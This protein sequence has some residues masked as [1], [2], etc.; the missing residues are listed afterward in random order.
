[1][2]EF[3]RHIKKS[4]HK[5]AIAVAI[6]LASYTASADIVTSVK[7]LGFIASSIAEGV[8]ETQVLVPP[9]ASPHDTY[10]KP[11]DVLLLKKAD[12]AIWIGEDV[13]ANFSKIINE[14]L[15]ADKKLQL[16][17]LEEIED[18]L[19]EG[20]EGHDHSHSHNHHSDSH[21]E[22]DAEH[23]HNHA[24]KQEGHSHAHDHHHDSSVNWHI[25]YSPQ[26]SH[27]VA[28][29]IAE[30][31]T[32]IYPD[33]KQRIAKNLAQFEQ[34]LATQSEKIKVQ[35]AP[36]KDRGF[37]VFHDAYGYFNTAY[38]LN[39]TGYFTINPLVAP[40]AKTL[41]KIK[42]EIQQHKVSCL[43]AEPQFT[44]KVIE[45]L[46]QSTGVKVGRL[47]PIGDNVQLGK[48]SYAAFLQ[49]TADSYAQ[50]LAQ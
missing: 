32:H 13:D 18:L 21:E 11:S 27:I 22:E 33:K 10:L 1:M 4:V 24:H 38:G 49:A 3:T 6:S 2:S 19:I 26:I 41:A 44:P 35:L 7:P 36:Y 23:S 12:L 5:S 45:S 46:S 16:S 50:C 8:T 14:Y 43:F 9:G 39:Q 42:Q 47:D 17:E 37:Y 25:W 15:G 31:L 29:E 28:Q 48:D 34:S 30:R 40:G 20:E